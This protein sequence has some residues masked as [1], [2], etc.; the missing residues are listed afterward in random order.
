MSKREMQKEI[1]S[2]VILFCMLQEVSRHRDVALLAAV[3]ALQEASA[4]EGLLKCLRCKNV[5]LCKVLNLIN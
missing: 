4:A 1:T 2:R 3:E 5:C